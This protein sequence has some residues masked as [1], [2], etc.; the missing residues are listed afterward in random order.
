MAVKSC[1]SAKNCVTMS[2]PSLG[3]CLMGVGKSLDWRW[4]EKM[5]GGKRETN[6]QVI[7]GNALQTG[8][9]RRHLIKVPIRV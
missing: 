3:H 6:D 4:M 2:D 1:E 8:F 5:A 7:Y 9:A